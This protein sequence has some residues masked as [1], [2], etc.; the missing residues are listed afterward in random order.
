MI[1]DRPPMADLVAHSATNSVARPLEP[2]RLFA[3]KRLVV[4][5]GT[6]FLG[7]VWL[8]M[9]LSRF[10]EL[11]HV[12]LV[13]RPKGEQTPEARFWADIASSPTFDPIREAHPGA[14]FEAFLREKIT[15]LAGDMGLPRVGFS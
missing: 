6:G 5:G 11:G 2:S 1:G 4:V 8:S 9:L 15:P 14:A 12:F 3:G 7:K 13:V 10:P